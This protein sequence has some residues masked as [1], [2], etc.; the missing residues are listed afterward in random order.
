MAK[1]VITINGE[2]LLVREDTAKSH[3]GVIWG[4]ITIAI[5]LAIMAALFIGLIMQ[6]TNS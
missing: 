6:S 1:E 3:R 4:L 5:F 2:N